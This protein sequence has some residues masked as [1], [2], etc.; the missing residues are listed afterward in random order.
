MASDSS[1]ESSKIQKHSICVAFWEVFIE[2]FSQKPNAQTRL[3]PV[4]LSK[5]NI[6]NDC[7]EPWFRRQ[8]E[9]G[10]YALEDKPG[11]STFKAAFKSN[12]R[13]KDVKKR[14]KH[15]HCRCVTCAALKRERL[16][17]FKT[18]AA[19][20]D[21]QQR[22]NLHEEEVRQWRGFEEYLKTLAVSDP[23][24]NVVLCYDDTQAFGVPRCTNRPL[25]NFGHE[26]FNVVP[27]CMIDYSN[28]SRKDYVF[29]S[30]W[31]MEKG[32]NRL[33]SM[34]HM[35]LRRIKS[36]YKKPGHKARKLWCIADSASDNK[37]NDLF[38]YCH[39]LVT[40]GWFDEVNLVF[41][42]VG[43]THNGV[44]STH[45]VLNDVA[46]SFFSGD[47]GHFVQN[48]SKAWQGPPPRCKFPGRSTGLEVLSVL[49]DTTM[50]GSSRRREHA[51]SACWLE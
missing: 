13:F 2:L 45:H 27:W 35:C 22:F 44:D 15:R 41:G 10:I 9:G 34:L 19:I 38:A 50:C 3:Y 14:A 29:S 1:S 4:E 36:N 26:R 33:I 31:T 28:S 47:L 40:A 43:H 17:A 30:K 42:P 20:E 51:W 25:K 11:I 16:Q 23:E 49:V 5:E 37:N 12:P 39:L 46:G 32:S 7:F 8:V 18:G 21:W 48:F 6:F 24:H